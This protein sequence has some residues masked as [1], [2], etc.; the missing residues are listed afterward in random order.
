MLMLLLTCPP[1]LVCCP[2]R[3]SRLIIF[4]LALVL[5]LIAILP[6]TTVSVLSL[7]PT[8]Y[9]DA[10]AHP[11]WQLAMAEDIATLEHTG[12]W[13]VVSP[14]SSVR[15]ITCKW[16]Y[17]IKTRSDGSLERYKTRL[18]ARGFQQEH[19][20][21]YDETFTPV[22]H[23]TTVRTVLVIA[24]VRHWSVSQ[25]DV[26]NAFLNGELR[27]E[28]YMQ[29]PPGYSIPDG[30]VCRLLRSLYGLKQAP[31]A[32]FHRFASVV[33]SAG[34]IPSAHDSALFVHTSSRG[35]TLLLLYVDKMII[36][37][38]DPEYIAFVKARLRDQ[39]LMTD[40][41]P[42][43]YFLGLEVS[44]TSDGFY[45]FR[46]KYIQD[47]LTRAA[48]GD[49][50]TV[51]TP[52]ELN[53]RLRAT[54]GD[55]LPD[56]T[57]Y[58]HLVGSLVYLAV[59]RPDISYPVHILSQFITGVISIARDPVKHELT[60]H[61][62]VDAFYVRNAVQDQVYRGTLSTGQLVAVKRSQ[63]GSQQGNLE[64]RTEIEL[65][66]R[67]H[68]KNVVSLVGFCLD[69]GEQMLVYEYIPN[70]TL[71]E[72]LTGNSGLL[73]DW[74][75]RLRVML[76]AAKGI[77]YLHEHADPPIVHRDIK[78][79]NILLDERLTAKVA[80]FG[81]SKLLGEDG[82]GHVT[83]Q[84]KGTMVSFM[85]R[86][87]HTKAFKLL[88]G[89]LDPEYYMTEQLTKKSD[90]YSFG[91]LLLEMITAKTPLERGRYIVREVRTALDRST[92][93][94]GLHELLDPVLAASPSSLGG[95][96][97]YV[98]LALRCVEEAGAKRPTMGEVVGELEQI[99]KNAGD[100]TDLAPQSMC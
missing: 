94:Y 89:Y 67:V 87:V 82:R 71:K 28:V 74:K 7:S 15:P 25:L 42:L 12:T 79:S 66:S 18:V 68:H 33:T 26:Q 91:V 54:D 35:W 90:V 17:K 38:D 48:L 100:T 14:P 50:R 69:Q 4:V 81:L 64:F 44:S 76:G 93:M 57:R 2:L 51:E 22:A 16:V 99:A 9:R 24:S 30:M 56:P 78:S 59:T 8:S 3:S 95:L 52:V 27:E 55:P 11:E 61:I 96:E 70:G 46:E 86:P 43:R 13:D 5:L 34:F 97:Q 53:V 85:H 65:L 72:S 73:L 20:R 36:T 41:G 84:V 80:D 6:L 47:L 19:N 60:K 45:I 62:G 37:G 88:P 75:R 10:L 29:P 63:Q 1:P 39:F 98:D 77:A 31:R 49:E 92:D 83:T 32:W 58:R 21:D 23:M 40:L